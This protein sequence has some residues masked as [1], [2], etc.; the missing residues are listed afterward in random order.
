MSQNNKWQP[1]LRNH[2]TKYHYVTLVPGLSTLWVFNIVALSTAPCLSIP[3]RQYYP[4]CHSSPRVVYSVGVQ[5][6][7]SI[8]SPLP[9][10]PRATKLSILTL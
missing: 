7:S 2:F 9:L 8:D 4:L 10:Y 1:L 3:E 5:Y 6:S